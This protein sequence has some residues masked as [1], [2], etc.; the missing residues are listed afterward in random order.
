[1]K[2]KLLQWW[3][4]VRH[5]IIAL[6]GG[7]NETQVHDM[8]V[9]EEAE[10][11]TLRLSVVSLDSRL[12]MKNVELNWWRENFGKQANEKAALAGTIKTAKR[13]K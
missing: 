3:T 2:K 1:M 6:F 13:R 7:A 8:L 12:D 4:A 5:W 11:A 9:R 10:K